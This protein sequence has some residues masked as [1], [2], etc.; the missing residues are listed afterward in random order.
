M[1]RNAARGMVVRF[2]IFGE[3]QSIVVI[4]QDFEDMFSL[5]IIQLVSMVFVKP[6]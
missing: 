4:P 1:A 3:W 5:W 2:P 6:Y